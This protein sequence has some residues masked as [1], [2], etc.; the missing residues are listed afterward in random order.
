MV[1]R[2]PH[3]EYEEDAE[4]RTTHDGV[5]GDVAA[6]VL[7]VLDPEQQKI[8]AEH[9]AG[10][11][12]CQRDAADFGV[13]APVLRQCAG[14]PAPRRPCRITRSILMLAAGFVVAVAAVL[15]VVESM[16]SHV[17]G[18]AEVG[19]QNRALIQV[20]CIEPFALFRYR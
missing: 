12:G 17:D 1:T 3:H 5:C 2:Q 20:A 8:F 15:S 7:G 19:D 11:E 13:F 4:D 9:L 6:Y 14:P 18:P 10:C 16:A